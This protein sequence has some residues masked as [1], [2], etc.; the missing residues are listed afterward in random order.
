VSTKEYSDGYS[1]FFVT[2][3]SSAWQWY[4]DS[5]DPNTFWVPYIRPFKFVYTYEGKTSNCG[6]PFPSSGIL[7]PSRAIKSDGDNKI[8]YMK[9]IY[10][11][12]QGDNDHIAEAAL[13][14]Y[15]QEDAGI[16]DGDLIVIEGETTKYICKSVDSPDS[17]GRRPIAIKYVA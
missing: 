5:L 2:A 13:W 16:I 7:T 1:N 10:Q 11:N 6:T 15:W 3:V 8:Y 9:P 17:A 4:D 14:V 12:E